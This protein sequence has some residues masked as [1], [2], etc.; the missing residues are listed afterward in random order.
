MSSSPDVVTRPGIAPSTPEE[1]ISSIADVADLSEESVP[2]DVV[3]IGMGPGGELVADGLMKRGYRVVAVEPELIGG[4][5]A[6]WGCVPTK[7]MIRAGNLLTEARRVNGV[8]GEALVIGRWS[9]VAQRI[10]DEATH[11]WDDSASVAAFEEKGGRFVRGVARFIDSGGSSLDRWDDESG[12][13]GKASSSMPPHRV[14]VVAGESTFTPRLGVVVATGAT[15][16]IPDIEGLAKVPYWTNRDVV[17]LENLPESLVILGGGAIAAEVGQVMA[18]FGVE[19]TVVE[20]AERLLVSQEPEASALLE[21]VFL[22]DGIRVITGAQ[23]QSVTYRNQRFELDAGERGKICA[24]RLLVATGRRPQLA[25]LGLEA[26]GIDTKATFLPTDEYMR[27]APGIWAVGDITNHGS[28]THVATYQAHIVV[29]DIAGESTVSA[30][31]RAV[32]RVVF[33]DPEIGSVGLSEETAKGLGVSVRVGMAPIPIEARGWIHK[34]GN[35]GLIKLVED[36]DRGVLVGALSMGPCGG[37]VLAMLTL[38]VHAQVPTATLKSMLYAYPTF[39]RA[40]EAA[41]RDLHDV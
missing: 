19:V 21:K 2:V 8:A 23:I 39:H 1:L 14:A 35:D 10:I 37:E 18:R 20:S 3:I 38:A 28:F 13:I 11:S 5:C 16:I 7:I 32:P 36:R 12:A 15:P 29:A 41:L 31:Y 6:E 27:V 24:E 4:E 34:V 33:T 9:L 17:K 26:F 40:V 25:D 30:D 22:R